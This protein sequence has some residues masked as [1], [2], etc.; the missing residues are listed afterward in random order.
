MMPALTFTCV[1]LGEALVAVPRR[2]RT[3]SRPSHAAASPRAG[4]PSE[5]MPSWWQPARSR[6]TPG[7]SP[8]P[9]AS[10]AQAPIMSTAGSQARSSRHPGRHSE[11]R[12]VTLGWAPPFVSYIWK[13]RRVF[14]PAGACRGFSRI[15]GRRSGRVLSVR[16]GA[17]LAS[18]TRRWQPSTH[19]VIPPHAPL[20]P[21]A[22]GQA[23]SP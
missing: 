22:G 18:F 4:A 16:G 17:P 14:A 13:H 20:G 15:R 8:R 2:G 7:T 10:L 19:I 3:S 23:G 21:Q 12:P 1:P 5:W 11:V 9:E 6:G